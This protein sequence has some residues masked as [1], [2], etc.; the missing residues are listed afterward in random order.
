M[1]MTSLWLIPVLSVVV[2]CGKKGSPSGSKKYHK[3]TEAQIA[4]VMD[5][6]YMECASVD[7]KP[8]PEGISRLL[9]LNKQQAEKSSF[10]SGFMVGKNTLVTNNHCLDSAEDC[11]NTYIAIYNGYSY[12]QTKCKKIISTKQDYKAKDPRRAVDYT[13]IETED[14]FE[15]KTFTLS[16]DK[17]L[18]G[19][20]VTAWVIDHTG[21]DLQKPNV[22]ESRITE[23]NCKAQSQSWHASLL[24]SKCPVVEGNSGSP[25]LNSAGEVIGVIWGATAKFNTAYDLEARRLVSEDAAV[26]EMT[27]FAPYIVRQ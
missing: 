17:A 10:C 7:G 27:H 9:T 2:A 15:G 21:L 11:K 1:K 19:D 12:E 20:E 14:E 18:A 5:N 22:F 16:A 25:A 4:Y 3:L 24:L 23:F 13:V 6:Q 26:T 8:C